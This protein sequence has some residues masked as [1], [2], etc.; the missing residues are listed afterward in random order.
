M[1]IE[2]NRAN[3]DVEAA[4]TGGI[5][6]PLANLLSLGL[7]LPLVSVIV[8][9][10]NSEK[11][12]LQT[13]ES[14]RNQVYAHFEC[15]IVEDCATD[16]TLT[17]IESFLEGVGDSRFRLIRHESNGGQ[18]VAQ[19]TGYRD[20]H[21]EFVV[22]VDADD[23]LLPDALETHLLF[24]MT[25][26]PLVAMTCLDS[27]MIN[28]DGVILAGHHREVRDL[29]WSWF[30]PRPVHKQATIRGEVTDFELVP[31]AAGNAIALADEYYWTTQ[32]FMMFRRDALEL[33]LPQQT[34]R[35][36]ICA[37]FYLVQMIHAFNSTFLIHRAGG[38]YRIH[39]ANHFSHQMLTSAD[40]QSSDFTRFRWQ[41]EQL[42]TLAADVISSRYDQYSGIY[43]E[44]HTARALVSL[45]HKA[46]ARVFRP[47]LKRTG[48]FPALRFLIL[49]HIN[50]WITST[51][52]RFVRAVRI[53]WAGY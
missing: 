34:D 13:L 1:N 42:G 37:D 26:T 43:G 45:P 5:L 27:A 51:R 3:G 41:S 15:I 29:L 33:V 4:E 20:S 40:Q 23:L 50:Y 22:F 53:L 28:E 47:L 38:A 46:H 8:T 6:E 18:L 32:S 12:I 25:C 14:I 9:A 16:E 24:H 10:Y 49:A 36:R 35:F 30:L 31:P 19:I 52:S 11:Y 48:L 2:S 17:L 44:F 7:H 21:G 39:Q